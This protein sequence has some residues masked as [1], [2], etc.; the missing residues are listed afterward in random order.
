MI[1]VWSIVYVINFIGIELGEY[2]SQS[3]LGRRPAD[4]RQSTEIHRA[5]QLATCSS[6]PRPSSLSK[7][8]L[9]TS[10]G[11][12]MFFHRTA[13]VQVHRQTRRATLPA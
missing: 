5:S 2:L 7:P 3:I 11:E 8:E 1:Y 6:P 13:I 10:W 4:R 12:K 9:D